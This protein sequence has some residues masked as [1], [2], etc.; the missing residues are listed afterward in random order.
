MLWPYNIIAERPGCAQVRRS[1]FGEL[2]VVFQRKL[3]D[4]VAELQ[5]GHAE[6]RVAIRRAA[7]VI[8]VEAVRTV[9]TPAETPE[10]MVHEVVRREAELQFLSLFD[11]EILE[12]R[13]VAGP[14]PRAEEFGQDRGAILAGCCRKLKAVPVQP[15]VRAKVRCWI[16]GDDWRQSDL[17]RAVDGLGGDIETAGRS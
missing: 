16:A 2:E 12:E 13:E 8:E 5:G 1:A 15:L 6:V 3:D 7:A 4:A 17:V 9:T 14:E 11:L 10:R